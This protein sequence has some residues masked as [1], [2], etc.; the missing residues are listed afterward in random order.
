MLVGDGRYVAPLP[1]LLGVWVVP[2]PSSQGLAG[3]V[4]TAARA[5]AA[6]HTVG[7]PGGGRLAFYSGCVSGRTQIEKCTNRHCLLERCVP[8]M[9][10][11]VTRNMGQTAGAL[12][13]LS[14][15]AAPK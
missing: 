6:A 8:W 10:V 12:Y 5:C 7:M 13:L 3:L 9:R 2:Y 1:R 15:P 11:R 4:G 14:G